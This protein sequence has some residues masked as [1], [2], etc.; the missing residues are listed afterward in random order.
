MST[1]LVH[2]PA[3]STRSIDTGQPRVIETPP[4]GARGKAGGN[5]M[6]ALMPAVGVLGS[7]GMMSTMRTGMSAVIGV[8][9]LFLTLVGTFGMAFSQRGRAGKESR[10]QRNRYLDYLERLRDEFGKMERETRKQALALNPP[11]DALVDAVRDPARL[12][13]RRRSD[14]DFLL[15]RCATGRM[16]VVPATLASSGS[17]MDPPDPFMMAEAEALARR[18]ALMP[19][20]PLTIPLDLSG[21]VSIVGDRDG[22]VRIARALLLQAAVFHAPEDLEMG[23]SFPPSALDLWQWIGWLPHAVDPERRE[24]PHPFRRI[25]AK[26]A[27]LADL[28]RDEV[29][30]RANLASEAKRGSLGDQRRMLQRLLVLH[31][32][33]GDVATEVTTADPTLSAGDVGVTVLHLVQDRMQEPSNVAIRVTVQDGEVLVEDLRGGGY[34]T[35]QGRLDDTPLATAEGLSRTLAPL[36]LSEESLEEDASLKT[37]DFMGL[38]GIEDPGAVDLDT[39]WRPRHERAFLRVP[40]GMDSHGQPVVLDL[41]ES[42]QLGMGPHGLCIGATGS[43]KSEV[44]RTLVMGLLATHSPEDLAMVLI[45]YK[46]GATFAPFDGVP[47]VAGIITNLVDDPS[48]TER[49]Y[50]S[51]AGEVQRRQQMLKD[52]GNVA[53]ITDYRLL[54]R[55]RPELPPYPHLFVLID[56]F[57]ELLTAR[58]DFIDLFLSIGRIGRSIG[59]HLLL[60]SQRVEGGKLRGLET[61]LSYRLGLRTFSEEES[62]TVL[63]TDDAFH[64]P[65]LPGFGYLKVDTSV[66]QRFR[67]AYVSGPY[68]GRVVAEEEKA[69][70]GPAVRPYLVTPYQQPDLEKLAAED[71]K[72]ED[73]DDSTERSTGPTVLGVF[74]DQVKPAATAVPQVWL[75]PLPKVC[76]LD[77][78]GGPV[79]ITAAR[80]LQ[81]AVQAP[82]MAPAVGVIDDPRKQSQSVYRIDLTRAGGHCALIGGPA[83]GKTTFLRTIVSSLAH[84]YTPQE[85]AVYAIDLA[86]GGLQPLADFPHVGGVAI[87]TDREKIRRTL[88]EVRGMLDERE[89]VFRDRGIDTMERLR[90]LHASGQVPELPVADVVLVLDN[91]GAIKT[92]FDDLEEPMSDLIQRGSSYGIHVVITML[93][94]SDVRMATQAL[95]GTVLEL[96]LNDPTDSNI[97][98][99]LQETMRN[100]GAG[101]LLTPGKKLFAQ[102]A[103]PRVD[104]LLQD[105][106]LSNAMQGQA[107]A[108][109][110]AWQGPG[111][112]KV[113]MLPYRLERKSLPNPQTEAVKVPIGLDETAMAPVLLDLFE[114]DGNLVIFGDTASG[115]TNL[116]KLVMQQLIDRYSSDEVV[117]A[118]MDPRRGLRGFLPDKYLGGYATSGR[119]GAGLATGVAGELEKRLPDDLSDAAPAPVAGP[120][121]IVVADDYDLLTSGGQ[122]PMDAFLP[123]IASGRDISLHFVIARR[124]SGAGRALYE[125]FLT[126][127]MESG[128]AGLVLSGDKGEGALFTGATPGNFPAGRG[129]FVRR[130]ERPSLIQTALADGTTSAPEGEGGN[131]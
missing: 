102:L 108:L 7:V 86:G 10:E 21:N 29:A 47:H 106:D 124:A 61:Y 56:E 99:R 87:R 93:R 90:E 26:P 107:L 62:R 126:T 60:A 34:M 8:G 100:A 2:R 83:S 37:V 120:K 40:L 9:V 78:V 18:F 88:E 63:D 65:P 96:R 98:R 92:T 39:M 75:P 46:G 52:A 64:L 131:K 114:R 110:S 58:P 57:G 45:D 69:A 129:L 71:K 13:E 70:D 4:P 81:F 104:S 16:P 55:Q 22:V 97:D 89:L 91:Y 41:K 84:S 116:L 113:R 121:V 76:T 51:L 103:L 14:P 125:P 117:F 17:M 24:G 32:T 109:G 23:A 5:P 72:D 25:A 48:L 50:A 11:A 118:V 15:V 112:P 53:N 105:D 82:P 28:I 3:R 85:V 44:L 27:E 36:R 94:W 130:G 38:L 128:T 12:W 35:A 77:Q 115:K 66:Y 59:V 43:G 1:R 79:D 80:G 74:V 68:K 30:A 20:M 33:Y 31:D 122:A 127:V 119:V 19:D 6:Q 54:R 67:A 49:A 123:Y 95:F 111:A 101:R 42:A 73:K